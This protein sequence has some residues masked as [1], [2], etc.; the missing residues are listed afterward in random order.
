VVIDD[1]P[2]MLDT[3]TDAKSA[4]VIIAAVP[5]HPPWAGSPVGVSQK[6]YRAVRQL[7]V[8]PAGPKRFE[9]MVTSN[10]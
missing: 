8:V 9:E 1:P 4:R 2:K 6:N 7:F 10:C 3:K 5:T